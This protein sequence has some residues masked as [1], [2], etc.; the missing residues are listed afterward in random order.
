[1]SLL[2]SEFP[3]NPG[4]GFIRRL[5]FDIKLS[6]FGWPRIRFLS[7]HLWPSNHSPLQSSPHCTAD[8]FEIKTGAGLDKLPRSTG[9]SVMHHKRL[10]R[11]VGHM[12]E[13][14]L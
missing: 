6:L 1:M 12:N 8:R 3:A 11:I 4:P 10:A 14:D 9:P 7:P 13:G 5:L 2:L